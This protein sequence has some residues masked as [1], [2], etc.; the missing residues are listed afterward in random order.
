MSP[1]YSVQV[2]RMSNMYPATC[3]R[4]HVSGYMLLVRDTRFRATCV[5]V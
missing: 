4:Q 3:I 2:S 5:L 1:I